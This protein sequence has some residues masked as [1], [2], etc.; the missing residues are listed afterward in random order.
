M[1]GPIV[2]GWRGSSAETVS[3]NG[4]RKSWTTVGSSKTETRRFWWLVKKPSNATIAGRRTSARS[5]TRSAQ[6]F[7]S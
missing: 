2:T 6:T 7:R 5:A 3:V 4:P 1:Y